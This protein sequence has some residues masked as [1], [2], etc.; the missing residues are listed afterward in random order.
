V[1]AGTV[2]VLGV[3]AGAGFL[4]W[5]VPRWQLAAWQ[6]H[7]PRRELLLLENQLRQTLVLAAAALLL[8]FG[9]FAFWRRA[10]ATEDALRATTRTLAGTR[11]AE[12]AERLSRALAALADDRL[13]I[14]LGAVYLLEGI[15]RESERDRGPI[16]EI[17][18]AYV[19]DRAAW[20]EGSPAPERAPA[21][22][23]AAL[24][25][26]GRRP[27]GEADER[28]LDLRGVDLR[29]ADL[30][31]VDLGGARLCEAHLEGASLQGANLAEADLRQAFLTGADLV[32]ANLIGANL[33]E[34]H[35]GAAYLVEAHLENADLGAAHLEGAY[36]GGAFL[37]G[38]DLGGA[39][40]DGAYIYK[41]HLNGASLHG[42]HVV[43]TIGMTRREREEI[44]R[45]TGSTARRPRRPTPLRAQ[46]EDDEE[47]D[48]G[49]EKAIS[50][51][52]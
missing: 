31:G 5:Q 8:G 30:N 42:A 49:L 21:D 45:T 25:V 16:V 6:S 2:F 23:Q 36:L 46:L 4:I 33:R 11:D 7:L 24:T 35:L 12:K 18:C 3:A 47:E 52:R 34:A 39:H 1:L 51:E 41:A 50:S 44:H 38:A 20:R 9:A 10:R 32:E 22:V 17:L 19:R 15:A 27:R 48:P 28:P 40:L 29:G 26:L 37:E 14:R 43:S 13:Q